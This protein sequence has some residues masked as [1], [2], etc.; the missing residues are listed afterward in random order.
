MMRKKQAK[1]SDID[2]LTRKM[3]NPR[4]GL[5]M[6]HYTSLSVKMTEAAF[7]SMPNEF[8]LKYQLDI[9]RK[10]F[11]ITE[12]GRGSSVEVVGCYWVISER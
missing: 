5:G 11:E 12:H 3:L 4:F 8:K 1:D 2:R 9:P 7:E 10:A 6:M